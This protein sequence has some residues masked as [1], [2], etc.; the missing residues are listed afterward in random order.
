MKLLHFLR[1]PSALIGVLLL[2]LA[3]FAALSAHRLFPGDPLDMVAAPYQW[4]GAD[5]A[6]P[7][8]TD[9]MGRDLLPGFFMARGCRCTWARRWRSSRF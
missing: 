7:L 9:L 8:G 5:H 1:Q 3:L 6:Y 2:A 4:P